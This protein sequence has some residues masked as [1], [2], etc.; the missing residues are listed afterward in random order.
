MQIIRNHPIRSRLAGAALT[1]AVAAGGTTFAAP[2][3]GAV[4]PS[5]WASGWLTRTSAGAVSSWSTTGA[6]PTLADLG[7]GQWKATF[8]GITAGWGVPAVT[9]GNDFVGGSCSVDQWTALSGNATVTFHCTNRYGNLVK[10]SFSVSYTTNPGGLEGWA[11]APFASAIG[12]YTPPT[13]YDAAGGS[14]AVSH[15][16]A[17]KYSVTFWSLNILPSDGAY[18]ANAVGWTDAHCTPVSASRAASAT[19]VNVDCADSSG[20]PVDVPFLVHVVGNRALLGT[21][22]PKAGW[23]QDRSPSVA[24]T[25]TPGAADRFTSN[26]KA[27]TVTRNTGG[28]Y[29]FKF[30]GLA[31]TTSRMVHVSSGAVLADARCTATGWN[32]G[33]DA[34]VTVKCRDELGQAVDVPVDVQYEGV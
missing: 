21:P 11:Y 14:V 10:S 3:A 34:M 29:T 15:T 2:H 13:Y 18:T 1:L 30:P 19:V 33:S 5:Q 26:G 7:G 23:A 16:I 24:G 8:T 20:K 27:V 25:T 12:S 28:M 17:G 6:K 4:T 9:P 31:S 32:S 22:T